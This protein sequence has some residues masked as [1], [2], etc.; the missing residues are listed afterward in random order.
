MPG[1]HHHQRVVSNAGIRPKSHGKSAMKMAP[2]I[3]GPLRIRNI[4]LKPFELGQPASQMPLGR[5]KSTKKDHQ[6]IGIFIAGHQE[7]GAE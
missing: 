7:S 4:S 1:K 6:R 2:A 3:M 5:T